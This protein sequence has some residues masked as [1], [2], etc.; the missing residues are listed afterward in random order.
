MV[1]FFNPKS[2]SKTKI[3]P[4]S[5]D[6]FNQTSSKRDLGDALEKQTVDYLEQRGVTI[7]QRNYLCKMGEIDI[8]AQDKQNLVFI[9]VRYRRSDHFGGALASVN[10]KKQ[11]RLIRAASHYMQKCNIT[12][13]TASRFDVIAISGN[14]NQLEFNW[15][16]AAFLA[17]A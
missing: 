10:L 9:E 11:R 14:L 7:L 3:K 17:S 1:F 16:K 2:K 4:I 13:K 8:I 15:I 12:N 5:P 6:L